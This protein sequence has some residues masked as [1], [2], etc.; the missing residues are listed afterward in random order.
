MNL[1]FV[2]RLTSLFLNHPEDEL[3]IID[4]NWDGTNLKIKLED[5]EGFVMIYEFSCQ[6]LG[7]AKTGWADGNFNTVEL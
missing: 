5:D 3:N 6:Q 2:K 4:W 7:Y 1:E